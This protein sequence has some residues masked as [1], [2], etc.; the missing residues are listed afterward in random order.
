MCMYFKRAIESGMM[1]NKKEEKRLRSL[2]I[3][4]VVIPMPLTTCAAPLIFVSKG[5]RES[6][7][8][9]AFGPSVTD[10]LLYRIDR[11]IYTA[12]RWIVFWKPVKLLTF[13]EKNTSEENPAT[14]SQLTFRYCCMVT[15]RHIALLLMNTVITIKTQIRYSIQL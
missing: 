15:T 6:H 7:I 9:V 13:L 8:H 10:L 2:T 3:L 14:S 12:R 5:S 4:L 11:V 1:K